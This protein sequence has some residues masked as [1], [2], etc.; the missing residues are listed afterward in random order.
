MPIRELTLEECAAVLGRTQVGRLACARFDQ[1]Y[2][3]PIYFSF[4]RPKNWLYAISVVGQKIDW[5]RENPKVCLEV[6]EIADSHNWTTVV[7][8]G[9]YEELGP[10]KDHAEI[11]RRAETLLTERAGSWGWCGSRKL[12]PRSMP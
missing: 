9:R 1:P 7:V 10:T 4:D 2:I 5:M 12:G 11:R 6:E 8:F 3:V